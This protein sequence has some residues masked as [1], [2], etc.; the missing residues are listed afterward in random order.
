[1][2]KLLVIILI[3]FMIYKYYFCE[4]FNQQYPTLQ[5]R[6]NYFKPQEPYYSFSG[7]F[8]IRGVGYGGI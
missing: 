3:L 6:L 7:G 2:L 1:M 4:G 5:D 8:G